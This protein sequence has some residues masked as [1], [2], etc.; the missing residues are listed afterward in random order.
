MQASQIGLITNASAH[1]GVFDDDRQGYHTAPQPRASATPAPASLSP[2]SPP[3]HRA[4]PGPAGPPRPVSQFYWPALRSD[5][6]TAG[7]PIRE[8]QRLRLDPTIDVD[9][10]KTH[11]SPR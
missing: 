6:G 5:G 7:N 2:T 10:L 4:R 3:Q 8:G 9:S 1:R 11:P